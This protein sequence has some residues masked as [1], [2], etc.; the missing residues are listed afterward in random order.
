MQCQLQGTQGKLHRKGNSAPADMLNLQP[1]LEVQIPWL[2]RT[3][4]AVELVSLHWG[5]GCGKDVGSLCKG[6]E[7]PT[8]HR[9]SVPAQ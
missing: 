8:H 7:F 9:D 4:T 2:W 6:V 1:K 5:E 3:L